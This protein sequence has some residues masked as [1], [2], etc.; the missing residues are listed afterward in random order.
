M[1][2]P[3]L[4]LV[5]LTL[6][7]GIAF[8]TYIGFSARRGRLIKGNDF[9]DMWI[10]LIGFLLSAQSLFVISAYRATSRYLYWTVGWMVYGVTMLL[11][12]L[13]VTGGYGSVGDSSAAVWA[14]FWVVPAAAIFFYAA[15]ARR[16][17]AVDRMMGIPEY[18]PRLAESRGVTLFYVAMDSAFPWL[19]WVACVFFGLLV[20][21]QALCL[22]NDHRV[23]DR[24]GA[25]VPIQTN[26]GEDWYK[27]HVW[28]VG[29]GADVQAKGTAPVFV[30][31]TDF[32]MPSTSMMGLAQGLANSGHPACIVD[33]PGYGWSEPGYWDQN[34]SDVVKSI[35]QALTKYPINN[36][37]VLVGWGDGGVWS[38]LYM[39]EAD[40]TRVVGVVL[41]DTFPNLEIL[42][43]YALNRTTTLQN[44]RQL[45]SISTSGTTAPNTIPEV[46][47]DESVEKSASRLFSDW[48]A[49]SPIALHRARNNE[50][51]G[52]EP[53]GSLGMHRSL[54]RNNLYY[55]AKYFEYGGTGAKL[56]QIL[57]THVMSATDAVLVYHHW[58]LRWPAFR[59][60][61]GSAFTSPKSLTRRAAGVPTL[62]AS[63]SKVPVVLIASGKQFDSNCAA[64]GITDSEDCTKWQAFAWFFY[65]QQIEYQQTLS[66]SAAFLL[67]TSA[68][69][70]DNK[71]CDTDFVWTR[72]N[73]LA[74]AI[75]KQLFG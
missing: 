58:P 59:D 33:R 13:L 22:A 2:I 54:F 26:G 61:S 42:Q 60:G 21:I 30:L 15:K 1:S 45:R 70:E 74:A 16:G 35:N 64:Q 11:F 67:C 75:V 14:V 8:F 49:V 51:D 6:S 73:W 3:G 40:Y 47:F 34:P 31:L 23:Y 57:L 25:L 37:L 50:W 55:Q 62:P 20:V 39:Q 7:Y 27:L 10:T 43:T 36:P 69:S 29:Y 44:L 48:R 65:R 18:R 53:K 41:L 56:Y 68:V 17:Y 28:C 46:H 71:M 9:T 72:P 63:N 52:F 66:Q 24:P 5:L 19:T 38:Q 32:G 4:V 12:S